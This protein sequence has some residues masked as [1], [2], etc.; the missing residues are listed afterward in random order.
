MKHVFIAIALVILT[1]CSAMQ[2][3]KTGFIDNYQQLQKVDDRQF[4]FVAPAS[5][6]PEFSCIRV[7]PIT[8]SITEAQSQVREDWLDE[9]EKMQQ[10][11]SNS[12][13]PF[14]NTESTS[15]VEL[16][17]TVSDIDTSSP[18][19]NVI[20]MLAFFAPLDNGGITIEAELINTTND[21]QLASWIWYEDR[22]MLD[23]FASFSTYGHA[24]LSTQDFAE[25]VKQILSQHQKPL[26]V[27][28]EKDEM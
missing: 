11:M 18:T 12:L 6:W 22:S 24:E 4:R 19:L 7:M 3:T 27:K 17:L 14:A 15:P 5:Q 8:L 23:L 25:Q 16:R 1:G 10:L 9:R 28:A 2:P 13:A 20:T 26:F 21:Q